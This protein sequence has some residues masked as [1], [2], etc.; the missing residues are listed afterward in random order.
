MGMDNR[1]AGE[2]AEAAA[3]VT[4]HTQAI[5]VLSQRLGKELELEELEKLLAVLSQRVWDRLV[6]DIAKCRHSQAGYQFDIDP[7]ERE[8]IWVKCADPDCGKVGL[9]YQLPGSG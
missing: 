7:I 9:K 5:A 4:R 2:A 1:Q 3:R 8:F 6:P